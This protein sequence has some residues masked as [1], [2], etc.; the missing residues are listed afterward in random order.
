VVKLPTLV[1]V[2]SLPDCSNRG[3]DYGPDPSSSV[4]FSLQ[5]HRSVPLLLPFYVATYTY[6]SVTKITKITDKFLPEFLIEKHRSLTML[7]G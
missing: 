2:S 6:L 5:S 4:N 7:G 1:T 3:R